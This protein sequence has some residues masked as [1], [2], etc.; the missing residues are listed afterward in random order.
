MTQSEILEALWP[1]V[2]VQPEVLKSHI[3]EIRH[4]LAD[5][6]RNPAFVATQIKRGYRFIAAIQEAP[7]VQGGP[8]L[9][10]GILTK[11]DAG[12]SIAVLPFAN[13]SGDQENEYFGDGL[14]EEI[15]NALT[16]IPHLKVIARTSAF[17]FKGKGQDIRRI[18]EVLGVANIL[19]GSVRGAGHR[20]R[21]TAQLIAASDGSH[22]W[23]GRYDREI[24]DILAVQDEI[25][26][27]IAGELQS[28][29]GEHVP[30]SR[31]PKKPA[32]PEAYQAYLEGRY[33]LYQMTPLGMD[34]SLEC[35]ERAI[36]LDPDYAPPHVGLAQRA[37]FQILY[38]SV[39]PRD[40]APPA[41]AS[42]ARA[43]QLDSGLAE[44]H[45]VRS[46]F[47]AFYEW[48]WKAAGEH[49][50][51][52]LTLDP[53]SARIRTTRSTWFLGPTGRFDE[54]LAEV[55][56]AL[57]LDPLSPAVRGAELWVLYAMRNAKA[58]ERARAALRLFP[59]H[60][61]MCFTSCA[62]FMQY[63][64]NDE[65]AA[66]VEDALKILPGNVYL[67]A[68]LAQVRCR[69]GRRV[70]TE[71]IRSELEALAAR[72]YV[73]FCP[74]ALTAEACGDIDR[75]RDLLDQAVDE[76]EPVAL[77]S[78]MGRTM[79]QGSDPHHQSLLRKLNLA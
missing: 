67:L 13:M 37:Y 42:L 78:V 17:A 40:A 23:S 24:T 1:G 60:W 75:A 7:F 49:S 15:I 11:S 35:F 36:Q 73:P 43:L 72:E 32:I 5:D 9:A 51:L 77:L 28:R 21:I 68:V 53:A 62:A 26:Q 56:R 59:A 65:A 76:R 45:I 79:G 19:E 74:R 10:R 29:L 16:Q 33:H 63:E 46:I 54:A 3:L 61:T 69:Q 6:A 57:D 8:S 31:N 41:L 2:F 52:A 64:L 48:N 25:S 50:G 20:L 71:E 66:A 55:T 44:A 47:S 30:R 38:L 12:T 70:E 18:A 4:A 34:R 22:V 58:V 27:A 39:R 14:A